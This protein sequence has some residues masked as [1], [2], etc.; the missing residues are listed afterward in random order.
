[1]GEGGFE[2]ASHSSVCTHPCV[3][4]IESIR[5][6]AA[7]RKAELWGSSLALSAAATPSHVSVIIAGSASL[8]Q[9]IGKWYKPSFLDLDKKA[10]HTCVDSDF[11]GSL[12]LL[13]KISFM[14]MSGLSACTPYARNGHRIPLDLVVSH[15]VG[16]GD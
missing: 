3:H 7:S 14:C 6:T 9:L 8:L 12:L 2:E 10:I 15:H 4:S 11:L 13:F 5:H 16:A 1:M